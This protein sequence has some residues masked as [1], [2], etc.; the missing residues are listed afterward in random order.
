MNYNGSY[1]IC[2]IS[3]PFVLDGPTGYEAYEWSTGI[4]GSSI[5][6]TSIGQYSLTATDNKGCIL[7]DTLWV[8]VCTGLS[9]NQQPGF[10]VFPNP[11]NDRLIITSSGRINDGIIRLFSSSG[12]LVYSVNWN[13]K[14]VEI[15]VANFADGIYLLQLG[16]ESRKVM[17]GH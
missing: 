5:N 6:V 2:S 1:L 4:S 12:A 7:R 14:Q 15:P 10:I 16:E 3:L 13:G 8:D 11:A 9:E 17:I